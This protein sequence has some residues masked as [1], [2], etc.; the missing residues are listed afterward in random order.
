MAAEHPSKVFLV[1]RSP[2]KLTPYE[3]IA[4]VSH[5]GKVEPELIRIEMTDAYSHLNYCKEHMN[6]ERDIVFFPFTCWTARD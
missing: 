4:I 6:K 5:F 2:W 1:R 3:R